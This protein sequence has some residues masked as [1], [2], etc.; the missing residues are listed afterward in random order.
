MR[1]PC[2]SSCAVD[3][4]LFL[5]LAACSPPRL[6]LRPGA[7]LIAEL[8]S[9]ATP[10][11]AASV[12]V[13]TL[14]AADVAAPA[15]AFAAF[16]GATSVDV[17]AD[18]GGWQVTI[19]EWHAAHASLALASWV[20]RVLVQRTNDLILGRITAKVCASENSRAAISVRLQETSESKA[21]ADGDAIRVLCLDP[22]ASTYSPHG[23][24]HQQSQCMYSESPTAREFLA[25]DSAEWA[26]FFLCCSSAAWLIMTLAVSLTATLHVLPRIKAR[27]QQPVERW[28]HVAVLVPCYMPN[29]QTIIEESLERICAN[30]SYSGIMDVHVP[31]NTP[32]TLEIEGK[33]AKMT[34]LHGHSLRC[35]RVMGSTSKAHNLEYALR[36]M[37]GDASIVV[38]FD[39]DHHPRTHTIENLVRTLVHHPQFTMAQ[40]AVLVERGGYPVLRWY[41]TAQLRL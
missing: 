3:S 27:N 32:H 10:D 4:H 13:T 33:L 19:D 11:A 17:K 36:H 1:L 38:I 23:E 41:A 7:T 25:M 40:G 2:L 6:P 15:A 8:F 5:P 34:E 28:P 12:G 30:C 9:T 22:K 21:T 31:Y 29:E 18:L 16:V 14:T 37:V 24:L 35:E 26:Y 39:A 20:S